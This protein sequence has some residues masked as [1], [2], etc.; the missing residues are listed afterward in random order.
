ME[1]AFQP[2]RDDLTFCKS[3][4]KREGGGVGQETGDRRQETGDRRQETGDRR[5]TVISSR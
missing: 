1:D 2:R 5:Q 3:Y 4:V